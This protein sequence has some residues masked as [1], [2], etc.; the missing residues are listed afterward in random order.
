M[1]KGVS[2]LSV[3]PM[4]EYT[5]RHYGYLLRRLS[6]KTKLYGEMTIDRAIAANVRLNQPSKV[7]RFLER[8][9][10]EKP[11]A[12]QLG[13]TRASLAFNYDEINL[14]VGCPSE[15]A[16]KSSY[17]CRLMKDPEVVCELT[18]TMIKEVSEWSAST[19]QPAIPVTVKCRIGVDD[20]D[21][22]EHLT[23]F[24]EKIHNGSLYTPPDGS[25]QPAQ[26]EHFI[27]HA[28]KGLLGLN[29]KLN[30]SVPPLDYEFY[31]RLLR[32]FPQLKFTLNGG[33]SDL[34]QVKEHLGRGAHGV[35]IGRAACNNIWQFAHADSIIFGATDPPPIGKLDLL[36]DYLQYALEREKDGDKK[37][38]LLQP[39]SKT[40]AGR[41]TGQY[42]DRWRKM[43][44]MQE[45]CDDVQAN[46]G[47]VEE[48]LTNRHPFYMMRHRLAQSKVEESIFDIS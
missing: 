6:K 43:K 41:L 28:R 10:N 19:N 42:L 34:D 25:S 33:I 20:L 29:T 45:V 21:S 47:S 39:L 14:N 35:M 9:S 13:A 17:G 16:S 1:S 40:F 11:V 24:I 22:Y 48:C 32:D 12:V 38:T 3:A 26:V 4:M 2:L 27:I 44:S 30:R 23:G 36:M 46:L 31:Y 37:C 7:R 5:H 18:R 8:N 15:K